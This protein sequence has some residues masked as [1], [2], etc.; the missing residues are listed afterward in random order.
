MRGFLKDFVQPIID[1]GDK[2]VNATIQVYLRISLDLLPTPEKS[3]YLFNLRDL[4]KCVQ[5]MMQ[6]DPSI[7]R[8]PKQM[9]RY[10]CI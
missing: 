2:I 3:H 6:A 4:S 1:L 8:E 10:F 9:L 5:G 7:I